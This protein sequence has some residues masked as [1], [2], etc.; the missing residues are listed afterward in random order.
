MQTT[1]DNVARFFD[2]YAEGFNAIYGNRNTLLNR[3]VNKY[4]RS[5]MRLRFEKTIAGCQPIEGRS[6][7][8]VGTGPG[9]FAIT[10]ADQGARRVLGVDFAEGMIDVARKNAAHLGADSVCEFQFGDFHKYNFKGEK[11]D[12]GI[13][14]GFMDY[15]ADPQMTVNLL[16]SLVTDKAFFSFPSS[17]GVLAWQRK[18]RYKRK[19]DLYLYS[20]DDVRRL[21]DNSP[22][23]RYELQGISRDYFV[24]AY[25]S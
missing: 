18:L 3:I 17:S 22:A 20:E 14:M 19:C 8:D 2:S 21:F 25:M 16:L 7:L 11:F 12:Y 1:S 5:S 9:H 4:L 6:V 10:L 15:M 24:T 13:A 23:K